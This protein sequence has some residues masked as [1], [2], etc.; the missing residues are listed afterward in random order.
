MVSVTIPQK[1]DEVIEALI[2]AGYYDNKAEI[3]RE[4]F[5]MFLAKKAE[6]RLAVA[7]ELYKKKKAT[8]SRAAEVGGISYEEMKSI[9]ID[10]KLIRRGAANIEIMKKRARKLLSVVR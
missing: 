5:R 3:L 7:I 10:E 8:I 9:L 2:S 4:A 1:M 6:L